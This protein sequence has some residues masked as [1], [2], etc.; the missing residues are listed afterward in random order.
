MQ[1]KKN[2]AI[3]E[4]FFQ[5]V[6]DKFLCEYGE[7]DIFKGGLFILMK[8]VFDSVD[9]YPF[10]YEEKKILIDV[11]FE[12]M[13]KNLKKNFV[14]LKQLRPL[15]VGESDFTKIDKQILSPKNSEIRVIEVEDHTEELEE[16][17]IE[18]ADKTLQ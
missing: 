5:R 1:L 13:Q 10:S 16:I 9:K 17:L 18:K 7:H 12:N 14:K 8:R 3:V 2:R 15:N 4:L 11:I 6:T